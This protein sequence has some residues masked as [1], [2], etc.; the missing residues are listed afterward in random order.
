M[1][2]GFWSSAKKI[3]F[4]LCLF[5][6]AGAEPCLHAQ[7][8][9]IEGGVATLVQARQALSKAVGTDSFSLWLDSYAL[10]LPLGDALTLY[11]EFIP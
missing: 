7:T 2:K 9:K 6:M 1:N 3:V 8:P 5:C 11:G 4:I 10:A